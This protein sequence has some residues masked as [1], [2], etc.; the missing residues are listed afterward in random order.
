M[1]NSPLPPTVTTLSDNYV[2]FAFTA[3]A[4]NG[5]TSVTGYVI[6]VLC[7]DGVTYAIDTVN[8][9][10]SNATILS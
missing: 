5:G 8:C 10:G 7:A 1:P 6:S 3:P 4:Y 9:D 2:K